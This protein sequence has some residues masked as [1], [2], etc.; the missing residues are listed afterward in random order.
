M[1]APDTAGVIAPPPL[2]AL[3]AIACGAL[4]E[5]LMPTGWLASAPTLIR[6]VLGAV[7]IVSAAG[8]IA[9]AI[10][11]FSRAGTAVQTR[12]PSTALV[13]TGVYALARNPIYLGFFLILIG[14]ALL[15]AWDWLVLFALIFMG[16]IHWGVVRR[17]ER[18]LSRKFG[19]AVCPKSVVRLSAG[20]Q[21]MSRELQAL[22]FLA[23]AN[24]IFIGDKLLTTSNPALDTDAQ[25]LADLGLKP[26]RSEE[27]A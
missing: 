5:W 11:G 7:L 9:A 15:A 24:S 17:E 6:Q 1:S 19:D 26:M 27:R 21:A 23:G 4:L 25:L 12:A 3:A 10:T 18:Y 14:I 16:L 22:C 2:I 13:T 8:F 20:R